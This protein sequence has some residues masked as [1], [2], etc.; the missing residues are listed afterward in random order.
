MAEIDD[1]E[2][3]RIRTMLENIPP[4]KRLLFECYLE[5]V[6]VRERLILSRRRYT[7]RHARIY[8]GRRII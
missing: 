8:T 1:E 4:N 7:R 5:R 6:Q 2:L 3:A